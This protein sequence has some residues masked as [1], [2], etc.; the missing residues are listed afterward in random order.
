[1]RRV[2]LTALA[3]AL[4]PAAAL[5]Q[6]ESYGPA[7][8]R[9]EFSLSGTGTS[10][11]DFENGS[12]GLTGNYGYYLDENWLVGVRQTFTWSDSGSSSWTGSTRGV[13]D[14]HFGQGRWR[15]FIGANLGMTYG[16]G[17][18]ETGIISPEAGLKYYANATTFIYGMAE[19]QIFFEDSDDV[20]DN[21]D[22]S[23]FVYTV[24][25]GFH[26]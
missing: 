22:D 1:M 17:V 8:G 4:A 11:N 10:D 14:Y 24:G 21:F 16:D 25:V 3:L 15:P 2:L 20:S 9:N 13:L 23:A 7:A 19:Y 12:F 18:D 5:A 26:F 6:S